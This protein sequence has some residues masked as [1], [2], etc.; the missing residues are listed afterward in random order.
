LRGFDEESIFAT[1]YAVSTLEYR[2]LI[3]LNSYLF[4]FT[5]FGYAGNNSF[6]EKTDH[7]YLGLGLGIAFETKAGIFNLTY[8]AGKRNDLALNL[9]QSKIHFGFVSLF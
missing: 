9:R 4:G 7:S 3:G 8:A 6:T 2:F 5:D 1:Y